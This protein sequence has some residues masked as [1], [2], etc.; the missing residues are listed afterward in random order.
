MHPLG[1]ILNIFQTVLQKNNKIPYPHQP[2]EHAA[3]KMGPTIPEV[4]RI[5]ETTDCKE[6]SIGISN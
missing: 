6:I 5:P 1:Q 4:M 2:V 3:A